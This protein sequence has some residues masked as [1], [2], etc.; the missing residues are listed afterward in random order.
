MELTSAER[1]KGLAMKTKIDRVPMNPFASTYTALISNY[2]SRE[3]YLE[4]EIALKSHINSIMLHKYDAG[5][6]YGVPNWQTW[7]FGGELEFSTRNRAALPKIV[8]YPIEVTKDILKLNI[9]DINKAPMASRMIRFAELSIERGFGYSVPAGS[10]LTGVEALIGP[11]ELLKSMIRDPKR[12]HYLMR[13][14]TDYILEIAKYMIDRFGVEKAS[15]FTAYPLESHALI[16]S[17]NFEEFSLPY[18][19]EII[20]TLQNWGVRKMVIHLCGDHINNLGYWIKDIKVPKRAVFAIGTEMDIVKTAEYLGDDYI[21]GGNVKN[22]T[23]N[24]EH[25]DKVYE[26]SKYIIEKMKD[27]PGGFILMPDCGLS[28]TTPACNVDA[29]LR[30]V[31]DF[32]RYD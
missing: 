7:D 1:M 6:G 13:I 12:I 17:K 8:K 25:P 18:T 2:T 31:K 28:P 21:I 10:A 30:A 29:M 11:Q 9:P 14:S 16:S 24:N 4:P 5:P 22:T 32:G 3:Y 15:A 26:E 19:K 20:E 27:F 23:L